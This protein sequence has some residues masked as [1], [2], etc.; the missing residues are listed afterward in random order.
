MGPPTAVK[1][2]AADTPRSGR[3]STGRWAEF[4]Q[5]GRESRPP[6][7][8]PRQLM[9]GHGRYH[10]CRMGWNW[11]GRL[12]PDRSFTHGFRPLLRPAARS[13]CRGR[14]VSGP[15]GGPGDAEQPR[16][17]GQ[18][19]AGVAE[20]QGEQ[21]PVGQRLVVGVQVRRAGPELVL[22]VRGQ[23]R[24]SRTPPPAARSP[25]GGRRRAGTRAGRPARSSAS[26]ACLITL[27]SSRTF[28]GHGYR[29]SS[30]IASGETLPHV[31]AQLPAEPPDEVLDQ[32]RQVV[33]AVAQRPAAGSCTRSA[34]STG[35][36][37]NVPS[38]TIFSRSRLV[39]A[40]D[41][42]VG[43]DRLVAADPLE[44]L[45][46]QDA[47]DLRL[48]RAGSCRRSRPGTACRRWPARTCR[49]AGGRP[50]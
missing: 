15:Q 28:P 41:P 43:L 8:H 26:R 46:L 1:P 6:C 20:D 21:V 35:P 9:P 37:R 36:P 17:P 49:S 31:L 24:R 30:S 19:P 48:G 7:R 40:I 44:L 2:R 27:C 14:P 10:Q 32:Q 33:A 39:A 13:P 22:D 3:P 38:A 23:A 45:P 25:P 5:P 4:A 29:R 18:V 42:D 50:R 16:R 11:C 12:R 34:G 47:E